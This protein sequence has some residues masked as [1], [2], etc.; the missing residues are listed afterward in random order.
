MRMPSQPILRPTARAI[1]GS[2]HDDALDESSGSAY[3]FQDTG[4][5]W[6]QIAKLVPDDGAAEDWFGR[7]V[8]ISGNT[9]IVGA[10]Y[11]DDNGEKSGSA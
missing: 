2:S 4:S 8:S 9:A 6:E 7:S 3:L 1:I 10:V 11:N 5:G